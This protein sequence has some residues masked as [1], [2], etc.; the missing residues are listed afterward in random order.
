MFPH[1]NYAKRYKV[2]C[3]SCTFLIYLC[4]AILAVVIPYLVAY[5]SMGKHHHTN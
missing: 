5:W 1:E 2:S 4:F 3:F